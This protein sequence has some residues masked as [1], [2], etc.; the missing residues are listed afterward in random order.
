MQPAR[1][2]LILLHIV[3]YRTDTQYT[4]KRPVPH[5][6][7][8]A[9]H[10]TA[11]HRTY[12][13]SYT[14][15]IPYETETRKNNLLNTPFPSQ[16][17][18]CRESLPCPAYR[19]LFGSHEYLAI[20]VPRIPSASARLQPYAEP[21]NA[22][23]IPLPM[24]PL[25]H[26]RQSLR[27]IDSEQTN[28]LFLVAS[29]PTQRDGVNFVEVSGGINAF[30]DAMPRHPKPHTMPR[31][32]TRATRVSILTFSSNTILRREKEDRIL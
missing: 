15:A 10:L 24:L 17:G 13:T 20:V 5:T 30:G 21:Q 9:S 3:T 26:P 1:P 18:I 28:T 4:V 31:S 7:P 29:H 25:P 32:A 11:L 14:R 6:A 2:L 16:L 12:N 27:E 8:S 23:A 22:T 19:Y